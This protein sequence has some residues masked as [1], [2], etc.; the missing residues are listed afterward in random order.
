MYLALTRNN[1]E[2]ELKEVK[3]PKAVRENLQI[4]LTAFI[5]GKTP[6]RITQG[7]FKM[8]QREISCLRLNGTK[9][10]LAL[11]RKYQFELHE[12]FS[13]GFPTILARNGKPVFY[14]VRLVSGEIKNATVKQVPLYKPGLDVEWLDAH[15]KAVIPLSKIIGW[16]D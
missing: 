6:P 11:N 4:A 12:L 1:F 3:L 16:R 10:T 15:T 2:R 8:I 5:L 13:R 7:D 9:L 14:E